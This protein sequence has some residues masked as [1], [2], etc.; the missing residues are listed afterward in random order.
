[1]RFAY[2]IEMTAMVSAVI[3]ARMIARCACCPSALYASSGPYA[4]DERPSAPRP[5]QARNATSEVWRKIS[6]SLTLR[7]LPMTKRRILLIF[8]CRLPVDGCRLL[9][10]G[11]RGGNWQLATGN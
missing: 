6:G 7:A 11:Y 2:A 10:T 1:M 9:V 4:D 3:V 8:G 5:T